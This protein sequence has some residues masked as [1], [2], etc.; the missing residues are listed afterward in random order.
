M[1]AETGKIEIAAGRTGKRVEL[2]VVQ[3]IKQ[4][5]DGTDAAIEG[6]CVSPSGQHGLQSGLVA[7]DIR[8]AADQDV[9][10]S[11]ADECIRTDPANKDAAASAT[12]SA[13]KSARIVSVISRSV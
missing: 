7:V 1:I 6:I 2:F 5:V 13:R 8:R 4:S 11:R 9:V 3:G 12:A 10:A